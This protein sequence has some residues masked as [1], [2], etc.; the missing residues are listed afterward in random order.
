M[1]RVNPPN[2]VVSSFLSTSLWLCLGLVLAGESFSTKAQLSAAEDSVSP[3]TVVINEIHASGQSDFSDEDSESNDWIEL[4][5]LS[6]LEINLTGWSLTDDQENPAKWVIPSVA[7]QP[8]GY[9]LIFASGKNRSD[10][11]ATLHTNFK[12]KGDG[13]YV[14]LFSK[15][16][17]RQLADE[18][19]PQY[20]KQRFGMSFGLIENGD[21]V[22]FRTPTPGKRNSHQGMTT[23][24]ARPDVSMERGF[25]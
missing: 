19:F 24:L 2:L 4:R 23:T 21:R 6:D 1:K 15:G 7:L 14:G 3:R 11:T 17:T 16:P 18:I 8:D 20:P 9:L 25:F 5:N 22:H 13:E 12:L 10:P